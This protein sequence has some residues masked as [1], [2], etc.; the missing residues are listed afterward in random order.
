MFASRDR[1]KRCSL[2]EIASRDVRFKR[3]LQEMFAS[4]DRFKR[5]SLQEIASRDVRFKR[6]LQEM[7]ASRDVRFKRSLQEM[8]HLDALSSCQEWT[9]RTY[10]QQHFSLGNY[11]SYTYLGGVVVKALAW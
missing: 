2:Q 9:Y 10:P 1:F 3:S 11:W 8:F 7:F 5:C 4:R 6:S